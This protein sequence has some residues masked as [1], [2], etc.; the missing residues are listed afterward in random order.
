MEGN[1]AAARTFRE[2]LILNCHELL[3]KFPQRALADAVLAAEVL[4]LIGKADEAEEA[5]KQL[6]NT[7]NLPEALLARCTTVL[8]DC[9]WYAGDLVV[10]LEVVPARRTARGNLKGSDDCLSNTNAVTRE[11]L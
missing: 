11:N 2:G 8:A 6:V 9:R 3:V 10:G 4:N 7:K 1:A 5:A